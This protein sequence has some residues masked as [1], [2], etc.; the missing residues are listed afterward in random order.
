MTFDNKKVM[1][2]V[3]YE[4]IGET[5]MYEETPGHVAA[6]RRQPLWCSTLPCVPRAP[7]VV[8]ALSVQGSSAGIPATSLDPW[9]R[10]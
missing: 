9:V 6:R 4:N 8:S 3:V 10:V 7:P 1:S 2:T 5:L